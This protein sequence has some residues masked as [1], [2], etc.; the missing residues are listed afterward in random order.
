MKASTN[1][2]L[3]RLHQE[4]YDRQLR[5][6]S[7]TINKENSVTYPKSGTIDYVTPRAVQSLQQLGRLPQERYNRL[8]CPKSGTIT[9]TTRS[10]TS[11]AIRSTTSPSKRHLQIYNSVAYPKSGTID[12]LRP[13]SSMI[14]VN[15]ATYSKNSMTNCLGPRAAETIVQSGKNGRPTRPKSGRKQPYKDGYLLKKAESYIYTMRSR[16]TRS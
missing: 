14:K 10:P 3:G 6:T 12:K 9:P 7:S 5:P 8:L 11:R 4:R 16:K 1:I 2:Q 13:T 15:L